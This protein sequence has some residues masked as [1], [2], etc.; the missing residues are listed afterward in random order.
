MR[1]QK[2][3]GWPGGKTKP[4]SGGDGRN[5]KPCLLRRTTNGRRRPI[6]SAQSAR[7]K[8]KAPGLSS[9]PA[10]ARPWPCISKKSRLRSRPARMRSLF[11]IRRDGMCLPG[12]PSKTTSRSCPVAAEITRAEP[13]RKYVAVHAR[14]L[15]LEPRLQI[16]RRHP[17][18]LLLRLEEAYMRRVR[19]N[20]WSW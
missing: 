8:E 19:G 7:P 3:A 1:D 2:A 9:P 12:F 16:L 5:A 6:F 17:R 13:S 4:A 11:S 14:Q 10:T 18:P 20:S 15:A